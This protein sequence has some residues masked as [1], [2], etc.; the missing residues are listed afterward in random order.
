[1]A[2]IWLFYLR[3]LQSWAPRLSFPLPTQIPNCPDFLVLP[4]SYAFA[5]FILQPSMVH[6]PSG[7]LPQ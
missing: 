3:H 4:H 5:P 7:S 6:R 1:M 2:Q